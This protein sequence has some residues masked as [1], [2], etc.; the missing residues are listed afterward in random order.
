MLTLAAF[1]KL[2][3]D[4]EGTLCL[5]NVSVAFG[6]VACQSEDQP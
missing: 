5:G 4:Y 1:S 2:A 3:N 6:V